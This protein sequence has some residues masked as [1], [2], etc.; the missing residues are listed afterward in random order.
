MTEDIDAGPI[1]AQRKVEFEKDS[2]T[3]LELYRLV[4]AETPLLCKDVEDFFASNKQPVPQVG[5]PSY[6]KNDRE[7]QR[8]IFFGEES[9]EQISAK[10]RAGRAFARHA[11][12]ARS[13]SR[14]SSAS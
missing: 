13:T 9:P 6:F 5:T 3:Y 1:V 2:I 10:I 7:I 11:W 8:K 4:E 12:R 14:P